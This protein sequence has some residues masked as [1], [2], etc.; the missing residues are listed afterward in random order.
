MPKIDYEPVQSK[1]A[2]AKPAAKTAGEKVAEAKAKRG[3][4]GAAKSNGS[5]AKTEQPAEPQRPVLY[6]ELQVNGITIPW[7]STVITVHMMKQFLGWE[8]EDEYVARIKAE[9]PTLEAR[10]KAEGKVLGYGDD[11]MLLDLYKNKVRCVNN[12]NNRPFDEGHMAKLAQDILS[13]G[14]AGRVTMGSL[15]E[16][17]LG[18]EDPWADEDGV[19]HQPGDAITLPEGTCNG[20]AIIIGRTGRTESIQHR[21]TA[22]IRAAQEWK[23]GKDKDHWQMLWP[24]TEH[25]VDGTPICPVVIES[26]VVTGVSESP[27]VIRTLDNV[28]PRSLSD[29]FYTSPLFAGMDRRQKLECSRML[30][31]AVDLLMKRVGE[32]SNATTHA[33][34]RTHSEA[35]GFVDRHHKLLDC[36]AHLFACNGDRVISA[37]QL[38]PG[39]C[40]ALMYLMGCSAS[41]KADYRAGTP[42]SEELLS[43]KRWNWAKEFWTLVGKRDERTVSVASCLVGLA[44]PDLKTSGRLA[45]KL[46]VIQ[47]A[48]SCFVQDQPITEAAIDLVKDRDYGKDPKTGNPKLVSWSDFGGID[49]TDKPEEGAA[50]AVQET[51]DEAKQ[52]ARRERAEAAAKQL[53]ENRNKANNTQQTQTLADEAAEILAKRNGGVTTAA[54]MEAGYRGAPGEAKA[55]PVKY[56]KDGKPP[57]P[58]LKP[59]LIKGTN[60]EIPR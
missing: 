32:L 34:H 3:K 21:G 43:W 25:E 14:W 47:R 9:D 22:L 27:Q 13:R 59:A 49:V 46:I 29:V 51:L 15:Q 33:E 37:M 45:E 17:V 4:G 31:K 7:A 50:V 40:A 44:D 53:L 26:I 23:D 54:N 48:W 1:P 39:Q 57:A 18:G 55:E 35:L 38:S 19:E 52:R 58:K 2:S 20:E 56:G 24:A 42:P 6:P 16:F 12:D 60:V 8:T 5:K 36:L 30:A 41:S 10:A 28:K 11:Y